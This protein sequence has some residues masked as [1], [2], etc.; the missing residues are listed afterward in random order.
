MQIQINGK[1]AALKEGTSF[2]FVSENRLFTGSDSYTLTIT[3]PLRD[4]PQNIDIFGHVNRADII[5][6]KAIFDCEIID[7]DFYKFGS[8]TVTEITESEVKVQ[9]LEGRSEQNFDRTFDKVYINELDLGAPKIT[10]ASDIEPW[11]AWDPITQ[12]Y[13]SVALPWV[14]NNSDSGRLHNCAD[15]T[16]D[17]Y[18]W[19]EDTTDLSWQPYLIYIT[20]KICEAVGYT[21][22]FADWE[23][24]DEYKYLLICNCL[25]SAWDI[26]GY[27]RALPHW[28]V[29]EYFEKLE[30]FLNGEFNIDHRTKRISFQ[31]SNDVLNATAPVHLDEIID[32]Y[33][34]EVKVDEEQCEYIE[35]KNIVYKECDHT[36]WK[37][38]SCDWFIKSWK[39]R[40]KEYNTLSE[41]LAEN[42][43]YASTE[44][45][46]GR[47]LNIN[48]VLYAKDL[49]MHFC[50]VPVSRTLIGTTSLGRNRYLYKCIL[51]PLNL[52]G[53][54]IVD[55][56]EDADQTEI[57]FVPARIDY[58]DDTYGHCLF[59]DM[60]GYS[61]SSSGGYRDSI[62]AVDEP[63]PSTSIQRSLEAGEAEKKAEYYSVVYIGFWD[64]AIGNWG[65]LPHPYV[66]N[67]VILDDWSN[68]YQPHFS[69]RI[70]DS[71]APRRQVVHNIAPKQK[72]T[73]KFLSDTIP[74]VR[75]VFT[76]RGKRY[77]CEKITATFSEKGMAKLL[78]GIF[79]QIID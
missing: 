46:S 12:G 65:K 10:S 27:A 26:D 33:S 61:E 8:I 71:L 68:Y 45:I 50:I 66:E 37:Y 9:F 51:Q 59:L 63:F 43:G 67:V 62:D 52:F 35:A 23:A 70:N 32:E 36:M 3:F 72:T 55:D 54:R 58:T 56:S 16:N 24:S 6:Q 69:L 20:K 5:A 40:C 53:G 41:L 48:D 78:K 30:L 47:G 49:D 57:E 21:P 34:T 79:Y 64:G 14:N 18:T 31:F 44:R 2:E 76:I 4:C 22:N 28:T 75:A 39:N 19:S 15:F 7:G 42:N 73:F 38:Y 17:A 29:D 1:H 13:E 77:I 11:Q 74:N 25:S 60:S